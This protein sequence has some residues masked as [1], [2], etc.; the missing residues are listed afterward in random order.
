MYWSLLF[1]KHHADP[2]IAW[3]KSCLLKCHLGYAEYFLFPM[4]CTACEDTHS[5]P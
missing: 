2:Y 3:C 1:C 5:L 4:F